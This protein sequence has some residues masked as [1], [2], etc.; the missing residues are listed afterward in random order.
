[1]TGKPWIVEGDY[2]VTGGLVAESAPNWC[3]ESAYA[4]DK[5]VARCRDCTSFNSCVKNGSCR[6]NPKVRRIKRGT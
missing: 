3:I 2:P 6:R 1:M 5:S 4:S